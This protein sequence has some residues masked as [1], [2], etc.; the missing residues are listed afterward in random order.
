MHSWEQIFFLHRHAKISGRKTKIPIK[1]QNV[2][3]IFMSL[4]LLTLSLRPVKESKMDYWSLQSYIQHLLL[5]WLSLLF[6]KCTKWSQ[7]ED[8][9][10]TITV[11]AAL[12]SFQEDFHDSYRAACLKETQITTWFTFH[13][14]LQRSIKKQQL[15]TERQTASESIRHLYFSWQE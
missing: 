6:P 14:L 15:H 13:S 9:F 10:F 8:F 7:S 2:C 11:R 5:L 12:P 1:Y 4:R 3:L